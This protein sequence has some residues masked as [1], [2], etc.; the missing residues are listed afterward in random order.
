MEVGMS[1]SI[2]Q[3]KNWALG[4]LS[5]LLRIPELAGG[6]SQNLNQVIRL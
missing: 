4:K 3:M 5:G 2:L 1:I 6:E